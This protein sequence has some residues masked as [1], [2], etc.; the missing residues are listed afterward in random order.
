[1]IRCRQFCS[2]V[3][4]DNCVGSC[5]YSRRAGSERRCPELA[6]FIIEREADVAAV[7]ARVKPS[8]SFTA[9]FPVPTAE[10]VKAAI[11]ADK[12]AATERA[13][14]AKM[15]ASATGLPGYGQLTV[16]DHGD[17][18]APRQSAGVDPR[19]EI[20]ETVQVVADEIEAID[21]GET[22]PVAAI[23]DGDDS[24]DDEEEFNEDDDQTLDDE[25]GDDEGGDDN[26]D[27]TTEA[28]NDQ[29]AEVVETPAEDTADAPAVDD[30]AINDIIADVRAQRRRRLSFTPVKKEMVLFVETEP[31]SGLFELKR[32]NETSIGE[33]VILKNSDRRIVVA[34]DATEF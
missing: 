1:M 32:E 6:N 29:V 21:L 24:D 27:Q 20:V 28:V 34:V 25:D 30:E 23:D 8:T 11:E 10:G 14:S 22:E 33:V 19:A 7:I 3:K 2:S 18:V 13:A 26:T 31:G 16:N 17:A 12:A 4:I 15:S 9:A 5:P